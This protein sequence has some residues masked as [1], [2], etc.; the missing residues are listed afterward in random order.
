[1]TT[2]VEHED[3]IRVL[4]VDDQLDF[5]DM[6]TT[7]LER[8]NDRFETETIASASEGLARLAD[9]E[10]DCVV[11]DYEMPGQNGI[12]FLKNIRKKYPQIPF[13]LYTGKG[14]E[15]VASD[16]ISAGATDYLQKES[17]TDQYTVLANRIETVVERAHA[18]QRYQRQTDAIETARE[19]IAIIDSDGYHTNVNQS[20]ADIHRSDPDE[21]IGKHWTTLHPED[22]A[23]HIQSKLFASVQEDGQCQYQTTGLRADGET[24]I[25]DCV[26]SATAKDMMTIT[27]R[28][29]SDQVQSQEHLNR[30]KALI[31]VIEDPVYVLDEDGRFEF[32]NESF[33]ETFGYEQNELIGTDVSLIKDETAVEQ[34]RS[35]LRQILSSEGSDSAYFE[36]EIQSKSGE[37]IPCEDHMTA[38]PYEGEYF[39]GTAGILRD[40]SERKSRIKKLKSQNKR[41]DEFA[42]VVS[43]DLRNPLSV[44]EGNVELLR[45][46]CNN[47]RIDT[48]DSALTRM[49]DLIEDLLQLART[50]RQVNST[51]SVSLAELSQNCWKNIKTTNAAVDID[52]NR[53]VQADR[54]RLAQVFENLMRNAIEHTDQDVSITVGELEDGFYIEDDGSG[55]PEDRRKD[56]IEAGY[57]TAEQGTGFGLS[58]VSDIIEAHGWEMHITGSSEGGARFEITG[59]EFSA[60]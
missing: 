54:G 40:I 29:V 59:V 31:E 48:I 5:A 2:Q 58:I 44:A 6:A 3:T 43:H 7:F 28:D 60:E 57:T 34:G 41:L 42:S 20:Y 32:I 53:I 24:F 18:Q 37:S 36:T 1:M 17:G 39:N 11:S 14:S 13:I 15:E 38:L 49:D 16:A 50:D 56:I 30:Y 22:E 33:I 4:H 35:N 10:F 45:E 51:D 46:E 21:L 27:V 26:V 55:I 23:E 19:G 8:E 12:E 25:K 52:T 47:E 9:S